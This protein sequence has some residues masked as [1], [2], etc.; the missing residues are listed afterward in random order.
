MRAL[1]AYESDLATPE[2]DAIT[3]G[4]EAVGTQ[5][6]AVGGLQLETIP[7]SNDFPRLPS[8]QV[9]GDGLL[10]SFPNWPDNSLFIIATAQD[11]GHR[12]TNFL[13]GLSKYA[14]GK[15]IFSTHRL[16]DSPLAITG[17][18]A[19]ELGHS[20]GLVGEHKANYDRLS[21]F[22]GHCI[23]TCLMQPVNTKQEM[24]K[25]A[26]SIAERPETSGFCDD[27]AADLRR[28]HFAD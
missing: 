13:F 22:A 23:N 10:D 12:E 26:G 27:C 18:V 14:L 6:A 3:L 9:D 1:L 15:A 11:L 16:G 19:H 7:T 5:V 17:L 8:F 2:L 24:I 28:V 4:V 20:F 21:R 25:A